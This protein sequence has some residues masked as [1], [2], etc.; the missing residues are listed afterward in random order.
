MPVGEG[1]TLQFGM[2]ELSE[3]KC[4]RA[5]RTVDLLKTSFPNL[6]TATEEAQTRT[7]DVLAILIRKTIMSPLSDKCH[8]NLLKTRN[9]LLIV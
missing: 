2:S 1:W 5:V 6:L 9:G 7:S 4:Y 8:I 3:A